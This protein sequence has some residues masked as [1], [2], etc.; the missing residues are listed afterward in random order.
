MKKS[1]KIIAAIAATAI[2]GSAAIG[3]TLAWLTSN[4]D[5]TNTFTFG[6]ITI[7][8]DEKVKG[9]SSERTES[10]QTY[11]MYPGYTETKDPTVTVEDG[12]SPCYVFMYVNDNGLPD[13]F[14]SGYSELW[15]AVETNGDKTLYVYSDGAVVDAAEDGV[16]LPALFTTISVP[17]NVTDGTAYEGK[18]L[19]VKAYAHQAEEQDYE[20]ALA[21]AKTKF[22]F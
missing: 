9:D 20:D 16:K 6:N 7:K 15:D 14:V 22:G 13:N 17:E 10:G 11:A 1:A 21:A 4:A 12:S 3:G 5:I 2:A 18:N 8:L 19:E